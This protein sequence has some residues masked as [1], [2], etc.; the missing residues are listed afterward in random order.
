MQCYFNPRF[1]RGKRPPAHRRLFPSVD[2]NPRFPRGKRRYCRCRACGARDFNPRFPRGKRPTIKSTA[3][4]ASLFQSTLPAGEATYSKQGCSK[5]YGISIHASR[6]GSDVPA[7]P[8]CLVTYDFNPR[9]PR[10][11][12]PDFLP[13]CKSLYLFQSTLP[14]GEAT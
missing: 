2:F 7:F 11:K 5:G 1:P 12:R 10:G 4:P 13:H 14:A 3:P 6:G 8:P 9:F